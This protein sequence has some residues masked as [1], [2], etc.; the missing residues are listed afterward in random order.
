MH[1]ELS[2]RMQGLVWEDQYAWHFSEQLSAIL[3]TAHI[4]EGGCVS[5]L[6]EAAEIYGIFKLFKPP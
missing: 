6:R 1:L 4:A 2:Q 3:G 5:N